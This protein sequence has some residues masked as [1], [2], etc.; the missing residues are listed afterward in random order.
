MSRKRTKQIKRTE[1]DVTGEAKIGF[2]DFF[3]EATY[4]TEQNKILPCFQVTKKGGEFIVQKLTG[5]KGT[6]FKAKYINH[7]H[8]MEDRRR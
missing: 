7:F 8:D 3:K 1:I 6:E 4:I 2:T 5:Q